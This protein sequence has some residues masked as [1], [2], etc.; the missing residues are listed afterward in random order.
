[1]KIEKLKKAEGLKYEHLQINEYLTSAN[2]LKIEDKRNLFKLRAKMVQLP[3]YFSGK[4]GSRNCRNGCQSIENIEH[5]TNC[6]NYDIN[7]KIEI[8]EI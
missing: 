7:E 1:M 3:A 6:K 4:F 5:V 8:D 2:S